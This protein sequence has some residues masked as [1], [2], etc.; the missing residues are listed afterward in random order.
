M[1]IIRK[2]F[3][4]H[5]IHSLWGLEKFVQLVQHDRNTYNFKIYIFK[6]LF[7]S[8]DDDEGAEEEVAA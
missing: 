6:S 5:N 8:D 4:H 3:S 7:V 1:S 2:L